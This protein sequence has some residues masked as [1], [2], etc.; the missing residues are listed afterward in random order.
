MCK[1]PP[2]PEDKDVPDLAKLIERATEDGTLSGPKKRGTPAKAASTPVKGKGVAGVKHKAEETP[3]KPS[4]M[5]KVEVTT[6][7]DEESGS[8]E[9][10]DDEID[11]KEAEVK[12]ELCA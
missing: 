2:V 4:K 8:V 6:E 7:D 9:E 1:K 10:S 11:V 3:S 12:E 5:V